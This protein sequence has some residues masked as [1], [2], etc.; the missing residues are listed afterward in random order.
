MFNTEKP[1]I[2]K[3]KTGY[4]AILQVVI[5]FEFGS[6]SVFTLHSGFF[7]LFHKQSTYIILH[8]TISFY[9]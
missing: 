8:E 3:I 9:S 1:N 2:H 4:K 7:R 5:F 6:S